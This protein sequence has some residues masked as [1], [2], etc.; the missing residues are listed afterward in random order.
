ML[1]TISDETVIDRISGSI[2]R[3]IRMED[4]EISEEEYSYLSNKM[5][6]YIDI[7]FVSNFE[8]EINY[9]VPGKIMKINIDKC[10]N[11]EST[12]EKHLKDEEIFM[13]RLTD[14][15]AAYNQFKEEFK[16]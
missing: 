3:Q 9:D 2:C 4:T 10:M 13:K 14:F 5:V 8:Y 6:K 11:P 16:K 7:N 15:K 1:E 12:Q